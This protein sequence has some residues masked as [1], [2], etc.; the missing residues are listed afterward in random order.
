MTTT[1][2]LSR[3]QLIQLHTTG[4]KT[5]D[6][7]SGAKPKENKPPTSY[8]TESQKC[9]GRMQDNQPA[10]A[11]EGKAEAEPDKA[12]ITGQSQVYTAT[13][14]SLFSKTTHTRNHALV[15]MP[16]LT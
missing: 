13:K 3:K 16:F 10:A 11:D 7:M 5:L 6:I 4:E 8:K 12:K 1:I 9:A 2:L 15:S 14:E